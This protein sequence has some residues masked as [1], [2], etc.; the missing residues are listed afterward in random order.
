MK[1]NPSDNSNKIN[2]DNKNYPEIN[3]KEMYR[4]NIKKSIIKITIEGQTRI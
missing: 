4:T 3:F 1:E 2:L